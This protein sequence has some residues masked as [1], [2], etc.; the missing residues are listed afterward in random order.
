MNACVSFFIST[1]VLQLIY[2]DFDNFALIILNAHKNFKNNILEYRN[3]QCV[4][5]F[6][7]CDF[8]AKQALRTRSCV[9][10]IFSYS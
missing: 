1:A 9:L 7:L 2:Y 5:M 6:V 4:A 3:R 8:S 10:R